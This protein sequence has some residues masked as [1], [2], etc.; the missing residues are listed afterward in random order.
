MTVFDVSSDWMYY[1]PQ[2]W[3]NMQWKMVEMIHELLQ[4]LLIFCCICGNIV[5]LDTTLSNEEGNTT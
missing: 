2:G 4:K 1:G 3:E 5:G